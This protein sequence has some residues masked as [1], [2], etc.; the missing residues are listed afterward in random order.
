MSIEVISG[1]AG[2]EA[3]GHFA[4]LGMK[5]GGMFCEKCTNRVSNSGNRHA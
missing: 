1:L 4:S 2:S 5:V 3:V